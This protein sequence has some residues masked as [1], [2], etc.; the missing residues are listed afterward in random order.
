M[1][2]NNKPAPCRVVG[3]IDGVL[4]EVVVTGKRTAPV[5][6][7]KRVAAMVANRVGQT[8][9]AT[10]TGPALVVDPTNVASIVA[11]LSTRTQVR[12]V[13]AAPDTGVRTPLGG[14]N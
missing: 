8:V 7:S 13:E 2:E 11:L 14:V 3:V 12:R 1:A 5:V 9:L 4:Y 6:G 10:P